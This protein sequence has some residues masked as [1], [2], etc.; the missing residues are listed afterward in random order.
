MWPNDVGLGGK[1]RLDHIKTTFNGKFW[2]NLELE[3]L[4]GQTADRP[5]TT[6][7]FKSHH[8]YT[9]VTKAQ[10]ALSLMAFYYFHQSPWMLC[11]RFKHIVVPKGLVNCY[12]K[13]REIR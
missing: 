1:F 6:T 12:A 5:N 8:S 13:N 7:M 9:A 4:D 2:R 3:E 11:P 10:F